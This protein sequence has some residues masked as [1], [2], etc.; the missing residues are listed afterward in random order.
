MNT[1]RTAHS[2]TLLNDGRVMVAGGLG[3]AGVLRSVEIYDPRSDEWTEASDTI[4]PRRN[5]VLV[6]LKDG[7]VLAAGGLDQQTVATSEIFDPGTGEWTELPPMNTGRESAMGVALDDGRLL[8]FGGANGVIGGADGQFELQSTEV[9]DPATNS[10]ALLDTIAQAEMS[11]EGWVKLRDGRVLLAG[12]D[13]AR[14]NRYVQIFDPSTDTWQ[15]LRELPGPIGGAAAALLPDGRALLAGGGLRCCLRESL[16]YSPGAD[17]WTP[18]PE[19]LVSRGGHVALNLPDGRVVLLFGLN[20]DLPFNGEHPDGEIYDPA[21]GT[22][23]KLP[24]FP[25]TFDMVNQPVVLQDGRILLAGGRSVVV[26]PEGQA[27]TDYSTDA[28]LLNPP[29][30]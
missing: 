22:Q 24:G 29:A 8:V 13:F 25:G 10:W 26:N 27:T 20:P 7:R 4:H 12:G 17:E 28:Y 21:T 3:K 19:M 11:W 30:R 5:A 9:Y 1:G 23:E 16:V 2:A 6:T 18:G 15:S 14:P